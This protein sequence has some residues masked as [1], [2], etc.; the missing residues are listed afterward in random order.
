MMSTDLPKSYGDLAKSLH[1]KACELDS[2]LRNLTTINGDLKD[3]CEKALEALRALCGGDIAART[4]CSLCYTRERSHAI[5]PCG[6][7]GFCEACSDRVVRR[8][9]CPTCRASVE[10]NI[11]IF[12]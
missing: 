3:R 1:T 7:G 5:L 12:L 11:R 9:R 10:G 6:H 4:K 8:A 2:H